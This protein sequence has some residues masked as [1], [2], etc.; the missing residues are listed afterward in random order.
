MGK[1]PRILPCVLPRFSHG[2]TDLFPS[3]AG[4][5]GLLLALEMLAKATHGDIQ[6][7][8]R[9]LPDLIALGKLGNFW[10]DL[11][12]QDAKKDGI[13]GLKKWE[14]LNRKPMVKLPSNW[15]VFPV[16]IFP[17][18]NSMNEKN[19]GSYWVTYPR[20]MFRCG[21]TPWFPVRT[22]IYKCWVNW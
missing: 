15:K 6:R 4:A 9:L 3:A 19:D 14:N 22:I 17:S 16:K 2:S 12:A 11:G 10:G 18:S 8:I 20:W 5:P 1:K 7:A 13:N 21:K